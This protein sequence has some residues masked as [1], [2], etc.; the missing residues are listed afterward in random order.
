MSKKEKG[1]EEL[2]LVIN[3]VLPMDNGRVQPHLF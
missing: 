1:K 2:E 3:N